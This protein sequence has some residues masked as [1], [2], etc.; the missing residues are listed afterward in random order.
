MAATFLD[1]EWRKLLMFNYAVDEDLLTA[2]LPRQTELDHWKGTCYVSLVGFMFLDTRLKGF[3]I[4]FHSHFEEVNLR[5]YVRYKENK[6]WKRG[7]VFIRELVPKPA[8]TLVARRIYRENY[9]TLPMK[10]NWL[11][12]ND[13]LTVEYSWK[14]KNWNYIRATAKNIL[15]KIATGTE[16]EFITEYY[17][18]YT[19]INDRESAEYRVE[20]PRWDIYDVQD[21]Q[22]S[23]DF[24]STYG[25]PFNLLNL[26][27]PRSV[28]LAEGSS[29]R[30]NDKRML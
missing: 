6:E 9:Q 4:P 7:V 2:Y 13:T 3:R 11:L 28:F 24:G 15:Q 29:I 30:V 16:E 17:W 18:G 25:P 8:L 14:K 10:H 5:I 12:E 1:A 22:V 23:V 20:H 27:T 19:K 26:L 21:F